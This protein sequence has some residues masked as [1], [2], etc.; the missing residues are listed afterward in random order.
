MCV[1][2]TNHE[3]L[4]TGLDQAVRVPKLL[5]RI[6]IKKLVNKNREEYWENMPRN[7]YRKTSLKTP[8]EIKTEKS[9]FN[10]TGVNN[11]YRTT[12]WILSIQQIRAV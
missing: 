12:H 3:L 11:N 9:C 7:K 8:H 5:V 4:F 6:Q 1:L 10:K 2:D